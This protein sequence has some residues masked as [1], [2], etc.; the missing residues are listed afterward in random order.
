[1]EKIR[2][3]VYSATDRN[4]ATSG[5]AD[6]STGD[7]KAVTERIGAPDTPLA[8]QSRVNSPPRLH[9]ARCTDVPS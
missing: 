5:T 1:M 7:A 6:T 4:G 2:P 9:P 8:A 3:P